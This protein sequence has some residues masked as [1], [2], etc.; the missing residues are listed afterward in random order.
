MEF[1]DW[2]V[3]EVI[4]TVIELAGVLVIGVGVLAAAF[5]AAR[6][7]FADAE[8]ATYVAF[9]HQMS[10]WLL[11][12][13]ELLIA[14]DVITTVTLELDLQSVLA[15][16]VLV[17]IRTFLAWSITMENEGR[18]P[19]QHSID[20]STE[21][22][23]RMV[24]SRQRTRDAVAR[25]RP[26]AL[27]A[28]ERQPVPGIVGLEDGLDRRELPRR[29]PAVDEPDRHPADHGR[30]QRVGFV[31][32]A[33]AANGH[34]PGVGHDLQPDVASGTAPDR[35]HGLDRAHR[36]VERA[37]DA[38]EVEGHALEHGTRQVGRPVMTREADERAPRTDIPDGRALAD[39]VGQEEEPLGRGWSFRGRR[40]L[41]DAGAPRPSSGPATR[42]RCRPPASVLA[43]GSDRV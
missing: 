32:D 6:T 43:A 42:A 30:A 28:G 3:A 37:V 15:L 20:A 24:T 39:E 2:H 33:A 4:A 35:V 7:K 1:N 21:H 22:A 40:Q 23:G 26:E 9:R 5:A 36:R 41:V 17:L 38:V 19:W 31:D 18:W 27:V 29:V 13:L 25:R 12:G 8:A 10:R 11:L 14:A 34:A 16:G